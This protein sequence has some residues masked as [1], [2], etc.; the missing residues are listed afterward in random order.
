MSRSS[1][2]WGRLLVEKDL[3][4]YATFCPIHFAGHSHV[5]LLPTTDQKSEKRNPSRYNGDGLPIFLDF[6]TL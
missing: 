6:K 3:S 5:S 2:E 4:I 1:S